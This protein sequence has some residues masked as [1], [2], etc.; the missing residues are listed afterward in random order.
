MSDQALSPNPSP[1]PAPGPAAPVLEVDSVYKHFGGIRAVNGATFSVPEGSIT[2]LIGPNGAG[3]T[4]LFNIITGADDPTEGTIKFCGDDVTTARNFEMARMGVA[5]TFQNIRLW[6]E[7]SVLDNMMLAAP[8]QPG[9]TLFGLLTRR[10]ANS[11]REEE[12][13]ERA[14]ELLGSFNLAEKASDYAGTL[15]GG[16]RKLLELARA[17]MAEPRTLLLDEP[18]AG[19]N[20]T[21]GRRLLQH[22]RDLRSDHGVTFVF[23]EHDMD[24][25]MQHSD[26]V[27]VLAQGD[28]VIKGPPDVIR[29]DERVIDAY[30]GG[31]GRDEPGPEARRRPP[32]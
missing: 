24:V 25:V 29:G 26:E 14:M 20:P 4:T 30:L 27:I 8:D 18:M 16:Q 10:G 7:M 22:M 17:L 23:I 21:L 19:I 28:T 13:A 11:R 1:P 9:E 31:G 12:V 5:R 2:A 15:S 32:R 6:K 3:K